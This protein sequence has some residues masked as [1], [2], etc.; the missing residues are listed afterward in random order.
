MTVL[1]KTESRFSETDVENGDWCIIDDFEKPEL[2]DGMTPEE[3]IAALRRENQRLKEKALGVFP[4][5]GLDR[6]AVKKAIKSSSGMTPDMQSFCAE[7]IAEALDDTMKT[8]LMKK[9][10]SDLVTAIK[11]RMDRQYGV[12]KWHCVVGRKM[13]FHLTS[14]SY[15]NFAFVEQDMTIVVFKAYGV[16]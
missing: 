8:K 11:Q 12:H 15:I 9:D 2:H 14:S 5:E 1:S 10:V 3:E 6:V 7:A 13:S 4:I 16:V